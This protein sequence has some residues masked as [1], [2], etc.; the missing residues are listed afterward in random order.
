M[1]S[2]HLCS[3]FKT[4]R[5]EERSRNELLILARA[6]NYL[7]FDTYSYSTVGLLRSGI[8]QLYMHMSNRQ[9]GHSNDGRV[10][11]PSPRLKQLANGDNHI[12]LEACASQVHDCWPLSVSSVHRGSS[13]NHLYRSICVHVPVSQNEPTKEHLS[14]VSPSVSLCNCTDQWSPSP[15]VPL[16]CS[17]HRWD[18]QYAVHSAQPGNIGNHVARVW[19]GT[20]SAPVTVGSWGST[21]WPNPGQQCGQGVRLSFHFNFIFTGRITHSQLHSAIQNTERQS[22]LSSV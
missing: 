3:M 4:K 21:V 1:Y 2:C 22:L 14:A 12:W 19:G 9:N 7:A 13:S 16:A 6:L 17:W 5:A 20:R 8:W 11:A 15:G 10:V 18:D